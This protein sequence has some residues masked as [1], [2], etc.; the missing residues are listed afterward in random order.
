MIILNIP[1]V[2]FAYNLVTMLHILKWHLQCGK[3][4]LYYA[5]KYILS[6]D[7]IFYIKIVEI[8]SNAENRTQGSS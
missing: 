8:N 5:C 2:T 4:L 7:G 6:M 1:L 3:L